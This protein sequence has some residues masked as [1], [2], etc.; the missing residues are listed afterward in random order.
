VTPSIFATLIFNGIAI[1]LV[2]VFMAS[3]FNLILS[4]TGIF[5]ITFGMFYALGAYTTGYL[6]VQMNLPFFVGVAIAT[7]GTAIGGIVLYLLVMR[8]IR[9]GE[10]AMLRVLIASIMLVTLLTQFFALFGTSSFISWFKGHWKVWGGR[11][12]SWR[13]LISVAI[14]LALHF[15]LSRTRIGRG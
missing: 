12:G 3:G 8:R 9:T 5:F 15:F 14:L 6:V 2:Y 13:I 1:G 10:Q 4:V 11:R 7:L